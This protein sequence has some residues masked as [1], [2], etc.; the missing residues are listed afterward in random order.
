MK[1][2]K[3]LSKGSVVGIGIGSAVGVAGVVVAIVTGCKKK[4]LK[5]LKDHPTKYKPL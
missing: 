3:K 1:G 4:K 5:K 2:K